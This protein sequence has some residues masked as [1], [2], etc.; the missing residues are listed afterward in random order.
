MGTYPIGEWNE[1]DEL[2]VDRV[3]DRLVADTEIH[4]RHVQV[5]VQNGVVILEGSVD[6]VD[7][8]DAAGRCAWATPGV[9]DVCNM[10][11]PDAR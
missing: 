6:S 3:A 7:V 4:G 11:V 10:L 5:S 1:F 8:K 9:N 2:L